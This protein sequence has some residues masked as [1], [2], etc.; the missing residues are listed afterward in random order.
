MVGGSKITGAK[1][2]EAPEKGGYLLE[3]SIPWTAFPEARRVK[4]GL[5]AALRYNDADSKGSTSG[6]VATH[7]STS[8]KSLPP[9]LLEQEQGLFRSLIYDKQL[10][11]IPARTV[12]GDVAGDSEQE[13]ISLYGGYLTIVGGG[14][15]KGKEFFYQDLGVRRSDAI[16][17]FEVEDLTGDGKDEIVIEKRV[18]DSD[19]YRR[20]L[21]VLSFSKG[22]DSPFVAFQHETAIVT[23]DGKVDNKVSIS[24]KGITVSQ[25]KADGFEP[26][27]YAE[28]LPGDMESAL[29]PWQSVKSRTYE[30]DGKQFD[31][32][33]EE[34]WDPPMKAPSRRANRASSGGSSGGG[35]PPP[36]P[37]RPPSPDEMLDR[38]YALYR[39]DHGVGK[40]K[41]RF[42]FVTNVSGDQTPER[43]LIHGKDIVVFG[44]QFKEGM[45]YVF[46]TIG[47]EDPKDI[48]DVTARDLTG[49]GKAEIVARAVLHAKASEQL[50]GDVVDRHALFVYKVAESGITRIFAAETG[51]ALE[52]NAIV[53]GIRFVPTKKGVALELQ[54]GRA[55]GWTEKNDPF[56]I[57]R[58]PYG[59]LEPLLVPWGGEGSKRYEFD[60]SKYTQK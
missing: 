9:L 38:V 41:P 53:A 23:K 8:G 26:D 1:I 43:V 57:D 22:A 40:A 11:Q 50:G 44:K 6:I 20:V 13:V 30:W 28:P 34:T 33:D 10:P 21:S 60:G 16:S 15:R 47:V 39:K 56:P 36:P 17:R 25:G 14:Y 54:P 3:A 48:F 58:A 59:G 32:A 46:I 5:R 19:Q 51:R 12:V 45:S 18:G 31:K 24:R 4:A 29:L 52:K 2:V 55:I 37:P 35:A 27:T 42:D 49:D 7:S